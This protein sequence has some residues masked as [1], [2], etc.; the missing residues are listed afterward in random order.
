MYD[1][2]WILIKLIWFFVG[3]WFFVNGATKRKEE[4]ETMI[5]VGMIMMATYLLTLE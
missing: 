2:L 3:M 4:P 1:P 5:T